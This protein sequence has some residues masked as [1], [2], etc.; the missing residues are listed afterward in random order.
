[1]NKYSSET[2]KQI[3]HKLINGEIQLRP[4]HRSKNSYTKK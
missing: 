3:S 1:M 4:I 2:L